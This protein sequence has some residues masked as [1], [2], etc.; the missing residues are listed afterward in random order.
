MLV[1]ASFLVDDTPIRIYKN[2]EDLGVPYPTRQPMSV[3]ASLWN[4]EDWATQNGAIKLNWTNSPF[5]ATYR[6]YEVQGCEVPWYK[7]DA[8]KCTSPAAEEMLKRV[9]IQSLST[10]QAARLQWVTENLLV[11]D[12]CKDIYRYPSPHPECSRNSGFQ[13]IGP[14]CLSHLDGL[15]VLGAPIAS[16]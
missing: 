13:V 12:Y 6:G 4:G 7:G 15:R 14:L 1:D 2:C 3:F 9:T 11:Y 16:Q 5:V 8:E 10:R